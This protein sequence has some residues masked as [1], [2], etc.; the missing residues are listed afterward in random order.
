MGSVLGIFLPYL[1]WVD[2]NLHTFVTLFFRVFSISLSGF[3]TKPE[4]QKMLSIFQNS[5]SKFLTKFPLF[6]HNC[7][8]FA[9]HS[10]NLCI[11]LGINCGSSELLTLE[12]L[13]YS[14]KCL[15]HEKNIQ[16]ITTLFQIWSY[17]HSI[18]WKMP[19][20]REREMFKSQRSSTRLFD[21][22]LPSK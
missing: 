5:F 7:V 11:F 22:K 3:E 8:R 4:I 17:L 1:G 18:L 9:I 10:L 15:F 13:K 21:K 2:E 6:I 19:R 20:C 12:C 14:W 16:G